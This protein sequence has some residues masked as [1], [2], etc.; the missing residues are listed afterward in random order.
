MSYINPSE[1]LSPRINISKVIPIID[2]G[3]NSWSAALVTW[4]HTPSIGLRWNG[5][6]VEGRTNP[7]PGTPQSRGLPTWFIIPEELTFDILNILMDHG[8]G[9]GDIDTEDA[10]KHVETELQKLKNK[11]LSTLSSSENFTNRVKNIVKS[12]KKSGEI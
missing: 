8:L 1:V 6:D 7:H 11:H 9:G 10:K 5:G 2:N 12:M 3:E 4:D